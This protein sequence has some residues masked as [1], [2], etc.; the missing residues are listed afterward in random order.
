ME[1]L[2]HISPNVMLQQ[3]FTSGVIVHEFFNIKYPTVKEY[4][5]ST[6]QELVVELIESHDLVSGFVL[7]IDLEVVFFL[8]N[9]SE[10][11]L[12]RD[13]CQ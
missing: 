5:L 2:A 10:D 1:V 9:V 11:Q 3:K 8:V 7:T 6:I 12:H 13:E 4:K